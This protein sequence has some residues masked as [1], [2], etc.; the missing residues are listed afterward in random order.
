[1]RQVPG[2]ELGAS[3]PTSATVGV[4]SALILQPKYQRKSVH[5]VNDSANIIYLSK[6]RPAVVSS[7][8]RLN[9]NGGQYW[10]PDASG[11]VW[12]LDWHAISLVPASNLCITEDW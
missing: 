8:I 1:M 4:V 10:E 6:G 5:F 12:Q 9:P 7:G 3:N 11:R 2:D